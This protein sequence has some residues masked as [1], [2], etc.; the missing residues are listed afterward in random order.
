MTLEVREDVLNG[1]RTHTNSNYKGKTIDNLKKIE[2]KI[3]SE[4]VVA[5]LKYVYD[6]KE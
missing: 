2:R 1:M 3:Y 6:V 4:E 5:F